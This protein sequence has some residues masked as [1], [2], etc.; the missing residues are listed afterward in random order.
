MRT[1]PAAL[2]VQ[3]T[4]IRKRFPTDVQNGTG[5]NISAEGGRNV[6]CDL[7]Q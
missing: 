6:F 4:C 1:Q 3:I 5:Y 7:F 2:I